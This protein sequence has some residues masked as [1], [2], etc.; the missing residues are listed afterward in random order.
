MVC[1]RVHRCRFVLNCASRTNLN[2]KWTGKS[3]VTSWLYFA[4]I[5]KKPHLKS[6][7]PL[8]T[9]PRNVPVVSM[10]CAS[11]ERA[12]YLSNF[13]RVQNRVQPCKPTQSHHIRLCNR[14]SCQMSYTSAAAA[15]WGKVHKPQA[16]R[17]E[18]GE[19]VNLFLS[20]T[21]VRG[22]AYCTCSEL[23]RMDRKCHA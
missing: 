12:R 5:S 21:S 23:N 9:A 18:D 13:R 22:G 11:F 8:L 1:E 20:S 19:K 16:P 6:F 2:F 4:D 15:T 3:H 10:S 17:R 7:L 14:H